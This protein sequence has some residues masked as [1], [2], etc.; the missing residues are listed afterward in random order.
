[1]NSRAISPMNP[2]PQIEHHQARTT[3][4]GFSIDAWRQRSNWVPWSIYLA[5]SWTWCIG[6]FLPVLLIRDYGL[7]G[8]IVFAVP[9]VVGAGAMGWVL[10]SRTTSRHMVVAHAVACR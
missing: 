10:R 5:S 4:P 8:W 6:M 3:G 1:M 7:W 9:N 2:A